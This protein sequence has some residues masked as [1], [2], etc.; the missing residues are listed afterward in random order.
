MEK[1]YKIRLD[2]L[3]LAGFSANSTEEKCFA[4][5]NYIAEYPDHAST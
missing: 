2:V 1:P 5:M 3:R 4:K